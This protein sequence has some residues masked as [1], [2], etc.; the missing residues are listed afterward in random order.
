MILEK[1]GDYQLSSYELPTIV[2]PDFTVSEKDVSD[3]MERIAFRHST[4]ATVDP[5]PVRADD[6]VLIDIDTKD[7]QNPFPGLTHES[8]D[9]QLGVGSL[10]EEIE[11]AML[12]HEV[13]DTV[14]ANFLYTDYSQ[15]ASER[16]T[17]ADGGCGAGE[18]GEPEEVELA[19]RVKIL[20][21]RKFIT[22]DITDEW[23]KKR[24]ALTDTVEE[25]SQKTAQK[26][27][28][29]K[30]REYANNVEYVVI[31]EIGK[32]LVGEPPAEVVKNV[33]KQMIREFESFIEQYDMD[34]ASYMAI[35]GL[36]DLAFAEQVKQD[37]RDRVSQDI[38]LASWATHFAIEIDDDDIDFVFGEPTPEKTYEARVEAE[39]SGR[40]DMFKDLALRAKIAEDITRHTVFL[41]AARDEDE[42]FKQ[43]IEMKY[44]K[45]HMVRNHATSDPMLKPPMVPVH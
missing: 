20:A 4:H 5:H 13:G 40:I 30:R 9:V 6:M 14:E 23:V 1:F 25:F 17:P 32:R 15:V 12:G 11:V 16:E 24:I 27:I 29:Q 22:P 7:G 36:D 28:K 37:A 44:H 41:N 43:E 19:S 42:G 35:Q 10:P 39:Q 8:V 3:E 38:A 45:Q 34:R 2:L 21:I 33:T 26:L 18:T 31:D